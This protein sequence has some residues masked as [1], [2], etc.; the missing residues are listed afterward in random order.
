MNNY[1]RGYLASIPQSE[2]TNLINFIRDNLLD[3]VNISQEQFELLLN[4]IVQDRQ[5]ATTETKVNYNDK[6]SDTYSTFFSKVY[7]D[8]NYLFRVINMLYNAIDGYA[9]LSASYLSDIKGEIDRLEVSIRELQA[10]EEYSDNAIVVTETF[11][12]TENFESYNDATSY[13]FCDRNGAKLNTVKLLHNNTSS[14]ITL[15][16]QV[17]V[18]LL[19]DIDGKPKGKLDVM[20]YRGVPVETYATKQSAIDNSMASYWDSS[21]I[22]DEPINVAMDD[23]EVGGAYI[24]FKI[25]LPVTHNITEIA[26]TPYCIH[27]VEVC[28]IMVGDKSILPV[29]K[30]SVDTIVINTTQIVSDE[31][32]VVLRQTNYIYADVKTNV[33]MDEAEGLWNTYF[34]KTKDVYIEEPS[35]RV[36]TE[37]DI[38]LKYMVEKEKEITIWNE[39]YI[40]DN[41][42]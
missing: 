1:L 31:I 11:K 32:T 14:M 37:E 36:P 28:D 38:Y 27:P 18:D 22:S 2:Y 25:R 4:Q 5:P 29:S 21:V 42:I 3:K 9:N 17:D 26:L 30:S 19:H 8:L 40:R 7:I 12:N 41:E 24:K 10:K 39:E 15:G 13:L 35:R 23:F 34:G 16:V 33:K 6:P 20:D